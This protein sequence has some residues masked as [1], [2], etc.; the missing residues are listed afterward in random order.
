MLQINLQECIVFYPARPQGPSLLQPAIQ[1]SHSQIGVLQQFLRRGTPGGYSQVFHDGLF[2]LTESKDLTC[3]DLMFQEA[4]SCWLDFCLTGTILLMKRED[5]LC[6]YGE[7]TEKDFCLGLDLFPPAKNQYLITCDSSLPKHINIGRP[8]KWHQ[9]ERRH[10]THP[11]PGIKAVEFPV[12]SFIPLAPDFLWF[13]LW[14]LR[15]R[16]VAHLSASS[17]SFPVTSRSN[18]VGLLLHF[19]AFCW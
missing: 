18:L 9:N 4:L 11:H 16:Q 12:H 6:H 2:P 13:N 1:N 14:A 3:Q 5:S 8:E 10:Y 19:S 15:A 17:L 7:N